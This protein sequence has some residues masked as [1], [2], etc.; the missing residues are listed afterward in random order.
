MSVYELID[1]ITRLQSEGKKIIRLDIGQPDL[2]VP[3]EVKKAAGK[4]IEENRTRYTH[5]K[6][7]SE[8]REKIAKKYNAPYENVIITVGGKF[9]IYS[10]LEQN[11]GKTTLI[12]PCWPAYKLIL[13]KLAKQYDAVDTSFEDSF[14]PELEKLTKTSLV[15][16][17]YP[18]NPTGVG[19]SGEKFKELSDLSND[20]KFKVLSDEI[21]TEI[22][23]KK[24][25]SITQYDCDYICVGSF[26]KTFSMTGFR[27]GYAI[28]DEET[29]KK[30]QEFQ[31]ITTTCPQEFSQYAAL[32]A[33]EIEDKTSK[34]VSDFYRKRR[35]EAVKLLRDAGFDVVPSDGTFYLFPRFSGDSDEFAMKL[36]DE[37][38]SVLPGGSFG[39]YD[40]HFRIS[41]V[42]DEFALAA[43]RMK[44]VRKTL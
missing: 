7:I 6:G 44:K 43:E 17:N 22:S 25:G 8:L 5:S 37:G 39:P 9:P 26:S 12:R 35:D 41:L 36:L 30:I 19:L 23:F 3:E 33:M 10:A 13:E 18:N 1:K 40:G 29:I 20:K 24:A 28:A 15:V 38:V 32:A 16:I 42:T 21:Y 11:K 14:Q 31:Q 2:P 27:L 4:A 34:F